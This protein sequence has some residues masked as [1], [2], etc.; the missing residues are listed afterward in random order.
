MSA[1]DSVVKPAH[2]RNEI[3]P[4]DDPAWARAAIINPSATRTLGTAVRILIRGP[5]GLALPRATAFITGLQLEEELIL[6]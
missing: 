6:A 4:G 3:R 2:P 5:S 1:I